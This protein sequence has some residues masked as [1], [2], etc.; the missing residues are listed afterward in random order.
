MEMVRPHVQHATVQLAKKT[1]AVPFE[2][3]DKDDSV[4]EQ[5]HDPFQHPTILPLK[6]NQLLLVLDM[7]EGL[8]SLSRDFDATLFRDSMLAHAALGQAFPELPV[9]LTTSSQSGPYPSNPLDYPK[10]PRRQIII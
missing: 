2:R 8:Y 10:P 9:V 6:P 5:P 3:L 1:S 4:S 7:Q